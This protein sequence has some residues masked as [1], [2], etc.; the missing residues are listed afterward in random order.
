M[1][2]S[3]PP[4][5]WPTRRSRADSRSSRRVR[6]TPPPPRGVGSARAARAQPQAIDSAPGRRALAP[7]SSVVGA[8]HRDARPSRTGASSTAEGWK[9]SRYRSPAPG[10]CSRARSGGRRRRAGRGRPASSGAEAGGAEQ[11]DRP[12]CR[13]GPGTAWIARRGGRRGSRRRRS[14]SA[15][16][17]AGGSRR[18]VEPVDATAQRAAR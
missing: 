17:A 6:R 14:G 8:D 15:R 12:A 16:R 10:S 4:T 1:T 18:A 7:R 13:P 2:V 3:G 5:T 9:D 11:P